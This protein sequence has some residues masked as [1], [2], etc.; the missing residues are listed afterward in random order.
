MT[1]WKSLF[2]FF[3][4]GEDFV[5]HVAAVEV[6]VLGQHLEG[7]GV[8][9]ELVVGIVEVGFAVLVERLHGG[10]LA[11]DFVLDQRIDL[12]EEAGLAGDAFAQD[13]ADG[14][15][16]VVA[17]LDAD[18]FGFGADGP[19]GGGLEPGSPED[20]AEVGPDRRVLVGEHDHLQAVVRHVA[21]EVLV[22]LHHGAA[23]VLAIAAHGEFGAGIG[24]PFGEGFGSCLSYQARK[25]SPSS[26]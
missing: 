23:E 17:L 8:G 6:A 25:K 5:L 11:A 13:E 12:V 26:W 19:R 20:H 2:S 14:A 22:D 16:H 1:I 9:G 10:D 15:R 24:R 21:G 4:H 18:G 3:A 7:G